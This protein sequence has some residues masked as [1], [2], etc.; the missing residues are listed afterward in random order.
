MRVGGAF[1]VLPSRIRPLLAG[2]LVAF[3]LALAA[4]A[5][6]ATPARADF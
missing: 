1:G 6:L 5:P 4:H 3:V 2:A